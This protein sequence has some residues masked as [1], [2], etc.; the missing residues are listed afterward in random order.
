MK[1]RFFL[2]LALLLCV[3]ASASDVQITVS[4][5]GTVLTETDCRALF[6]GQADTAE[7]GRFVT[8]VV[9]REDLEALE[10]YY[11]GAVG[12]DVLILPCRGEAAAFCECHCGC[13]LLRPV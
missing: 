13:V 3:S 10:A 2:L 8:V 11:G 12:A 1:Q 9:S 5:D 4:P 7:D 6:L